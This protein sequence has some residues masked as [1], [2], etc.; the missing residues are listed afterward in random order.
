MRMTRTADLLRLNVPA[1]LPPWTSTVGGR[2]APLLMPSGRVPIVMIVT[3]AGVVAGTKSRR[4]RVG[5]LGRMPT[6]G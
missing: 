5:V 1:V 3:V 6:T 2:R 4:C